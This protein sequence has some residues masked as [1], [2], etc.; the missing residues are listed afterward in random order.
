MSCLLLIAG[1]CFLDPAT[2]TLR[3]ESVWQ[4]DTERAFY[5]H[6]G[7]PYAGPLGR[8][9][10]V[11]DVELPRGFRLHYGYGHQ[12]YLHTHRDRGYEYVIG[13]FSWQPFGGVR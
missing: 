7:R 12:S 4:A 9:E 3:A 13:G 6:Q 11:V 8:I 2:I 5:F 1:T 10:L